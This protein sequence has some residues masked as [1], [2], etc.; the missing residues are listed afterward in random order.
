VA[1]RNDDGCIMSSQN[2]QWDDVLDDQDQGQQQQGKGLRAQLEAALK[3]AKAA[4]DRA[5]KAESRAREALVGG[6][7]AAKGLP[8]KVAKLLPADVEATDDAV[9]KWLDDYAD[10]FSPKPAEPTVS[11]QDEGASDGVADQM[12][13]IGAAVTGA[14]APEKEAELLSRLQD[15]NL[16]R[17]QLDALVFAAGGGYGSG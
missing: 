16:T 4:E 11:A 8:A 5:A 9:G 2:D 7:V 3:A 17:E 1:V 14:K 13:R 10:V 12:G 15:P 6:L